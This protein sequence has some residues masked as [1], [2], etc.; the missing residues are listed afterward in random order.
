ML[1]AFVMKPTSLISTP[2]PLYQAPVWK[3][4]SPMFFENPTPDPM[5]E[6]DVRVE[7]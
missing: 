7:S 4:T 2:G 1:F 6:S 3:R 5:P